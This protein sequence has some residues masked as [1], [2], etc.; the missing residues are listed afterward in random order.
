[1]AQQK[2]V[3]AFLESYPR[4]DSGKSENVPV[5]MDV[6]GRVYTAFGQECCKGVITLMLMGTY[7]TEGAESLFVE[8][9]MIS[10]LLEGG[11]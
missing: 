8:S 9:G 3:G 2:V 4:L 11:Q 5:Q 7:G 1:M 6:L 10:I